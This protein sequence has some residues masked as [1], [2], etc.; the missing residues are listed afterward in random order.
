M[1]KTGVAELKARLSEYLRA[2]RRGHEI[3]IL[4]RDTPVARLVPY[5]ASGALRVREPAGRHRKL[6]D[7]PIPPALKLDV[8]PVDLLLEDRRQDE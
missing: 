2:A 5:A 6:A 8:D 7:V 4:D 3:T 1:K